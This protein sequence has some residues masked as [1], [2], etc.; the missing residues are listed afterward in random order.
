MATKGSWSNQALTDNDLSDIM[1]E[2]HSLV[3]KYKLFG[4]QLGVKLSDIEIIEA[5]C[6]KSSDRLLEVISLRLKKDQALT[7]EGIYSALKSPSVGESQIAKGICTKYGRLTS[8]SEKLSEKPQNK[9]F[10]SETLLKRTQQKVEI[11]KKRSEPEKEKAAYEARSGSKVQL[12]GR[13]R[14]SQVHK[15]LSE[16]REQKEVPIESESESSAASS[17]EEEVDKSEIHS[18]DFSEQEQ[19]SGEE[20]RGKEYQKNSEQTTGGEYASESETEVKRKTV[21]SKGSQG[22]YGGKEKQKRDQ[23]C[24]TG[25]RH[26]NSERDAQKRKQK[27]SKKSEI[28]SSS[29]C[30]E[31][32][33]VSSPYYRGKAGKSQTAEETEPGKQISR[34]EAER[35]KEKGTAKLMKQ[36]IAKEKAQY[37]LEE[38]YSDEEVKENPALKHMTP[39]QV[40]TKSKSKE[41]NEKSYSACTSEEDSE[42]EDWDSYDDRRED[43][44]G[45]DSEQKSSN[46]ENEEEETEHDDGST[47]EEEVKETASGKSGESQREYST[48]EGKDITRKRKQKEANDESDT[49]CGGRDQGPKKRGIIKKHRERSGSPTARGSSQ[50]DSLEQPGSQGKRKQKGKG[51]GVRISKREKAQVPVRQMVLHLNVIISSLKLKVRV[52]EIFSSVSLADSAF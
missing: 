15:E 35:Q 18:E 26:K 4:V 20:V 3:H 37:V 36:N 19:N 29:I 12:K 17:S 41:K 43:G 30:G 24:D 40:Q 13:E 42:D 25:N 21:K 16:Q 10:T 23:Q 44:G 9:S 7:W 49:G 28:Q 50:E 48:T 39:K 14:S 32:E 47:S 8:E 31:D 33:M 6:S 51:K 1:N 46:E 52:L 27:V 22:E 11:V 38:Q 2:L 45:R 34:K 5:D